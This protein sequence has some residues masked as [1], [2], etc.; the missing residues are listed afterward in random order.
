MGLFNKFRKNTPTSSASARNNI[1]EFDSLVRELMARDDVQDREDIC[2]HIYARAQKLLEMPTQETVR[3]AYDL[4]G[5]L[6][7]QFGYA[8]AMLR[9]GDFMENV[10]QNDESACN[11]YKRAADLGNGNAARNYADMLMAGK[12]VQKDQ[13]EA[14]RYYRMAMDKGV[15]EAAFFVG[16]FLRNM[17]N[18]EGTVMAYQKALNLG[19]APARVRL[20]QMKTT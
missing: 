5:N 2:E 11:W 1:S 15:P 16:E 18:A 3:R 10:Q 4:M 17:G 19:Y 20:E 6:A 7:A 9:M 12:G 13:R 8:P 14:F